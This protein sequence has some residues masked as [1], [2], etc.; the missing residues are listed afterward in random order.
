MSSFASRAAIRPSITRSVGRRSVGSVSRTAAGFGE[1][2]DDFVSRQPPATSTSAATR[3][4]RHPVQAPLGSA[5]TRSSAWGTSPDAA[6]ETAEARGGP[7]CALRLA[8]VEMSSPSCL[9]MMHAPQG[10][11]PHEAMHEESQLP[12]SD[13]GERKGADSRVR[14]L[15]EPAHRQ[16]RRRSERLSCAHGEA[17]RTG[18]VVSRRAT[19]SSAHPARASFRSRPRRHRGS[20]RPPGPRR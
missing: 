1:S 2:S 16:H 9:V 8:R 12:G 17:G 7:H 18:G 10:S 3:C 14:S 4:R 15:A 19:R 20:F 11:A 6:P 13:T 5:C